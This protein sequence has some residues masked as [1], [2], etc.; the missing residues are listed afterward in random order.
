MIFE[1]LQNGSFLVETLFKLCD[2]SLQKKTVSLGDTG[3]NEIFQLQKKI[4][5]KISYISHNYT[6]IILSIKIDL[7]NYIILMMLNQFMI[8][9]TAYFDLRHEME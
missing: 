6:L 5:I 1:L 9:S 7:T 8:E 2:N 3:I 4:I